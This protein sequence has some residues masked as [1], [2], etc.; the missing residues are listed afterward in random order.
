MLLYYVCTYYNTLVY[1]SLPLS[2]INAL[3]GDRVCTIILYTKKPETPP[4]HP[5][6]AAL[7]P[8]ISL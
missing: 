4:A 2:L 1:F 3:S 5:V 8:F 6:F 7:C